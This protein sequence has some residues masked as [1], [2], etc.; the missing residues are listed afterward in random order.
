MRLVIG[1]I[2][3]R[4][5]WKRYIHE[6]FT[7]CYFVGDYFDSYDL[8]FTRQYR[9][10]KEIC[11]RARKDKRIKLCLGNHEYHY[12]DVGQQYSGYQE[13][14]FYHIYQILEQN[15]DLL[16]VVYVTRDKY[17]ISHAGVSTW[18]MKRM[19]KAGYNAVEDINRAF[20]EDRHI[21]HFNGLNPF[22][23]DITQSPI[24]IRPDSLEQQPL[25]GYSQIVG[26]TPV[27]DI[28]TINLRDSRQHNITITYIDTDTGESIYRF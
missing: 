23:D 1:D 15:M 4:D 19:K 13:E 11:Q 20:A 2:H 7:E 5:F 22:G 26:H 25:A 10:F 16:Q 6:D 28:R 14:H 8:S 12:L 17:I 9:N 21:L 18:F 24:W 3:G 27:E